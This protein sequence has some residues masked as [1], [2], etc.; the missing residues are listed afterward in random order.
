MLQEHELVEGGVSDRTNQ[1]DRGAGRCYLVANMT[2]I[3]CIY[4]NSTGNSLH[5]VFK[6]QEAGYKS[7][8][9]K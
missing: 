9:E 4:E 3:H 7:M 1:Q 5:T 2:D 8:Y 6:K